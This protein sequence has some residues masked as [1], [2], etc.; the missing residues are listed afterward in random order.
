L[1]RK[2]A[3]QEAL[4]IATEELAWMGGHAFYER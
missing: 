1:D 4:W 3:R 2:K